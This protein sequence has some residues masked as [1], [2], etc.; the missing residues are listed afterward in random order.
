MGCSKSNTKRDFAK[1]VLRKT[2]K[3]EASHFLI[4]KSFIKLQ[5]SK[6]FSTGIKADIQIDE[7]N[8]H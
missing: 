4:Q 7:T 3:L 1:S 2:T 8:S 5:Y 6:Q